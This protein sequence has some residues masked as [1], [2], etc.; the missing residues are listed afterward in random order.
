MVPVMEETQMDAG[1]PVELVTA[2][3]Q[4]IQPQ[5]NQKTIH[6][7][8]LTGFMGAGKSSAGVALAARLGWEFADLDTL[9]EERMG[10][11]IAELFAR[12]G[13]TA[14]RLM[15]S[16]A[17][18]R[19][20][21][22]KNIVLALGG[23]AVETLTNRLLLEQTPGTLNVFLDAPFH[24]LHG[25]VTQQAAG[26][27]RPVFVDATAAEKRFLLRLPFYHRIAG[28]HVDTAGLDL[29]QTV[30]ALHTNIQKHVGRQ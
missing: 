12:D 27:V 29:Q 23:G 20:L 6:R 7:I 3:T 25:R 26:A 16:S 10:L 2:M 1:R 9:V 18:A 14:F 11:T 13:E 28:V 4:A 24:V 15:E 30:D 22:R 17:L 5:A 21:A 8:V 19:A